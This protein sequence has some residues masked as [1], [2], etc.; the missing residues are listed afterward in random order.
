MR[1]IDVHTHNIIR[2]GSPFFIMNIMSDFDQIS[3]V[4]GFYSAG[5][6]PWYLMEKNVE[7]EFSLLEKRLNNSNVL[8]VG[9]CGLDKLCTI[10]WSLQELWFEKQVL[11]ANEVMKPLIV[12]C[13][14]AFDEILAM[15]K[16]SKVIVPVIFHGYEKSESVAFKILQ[17]NPN[18]YLS[19]GK[20]L[21]NKHIANVFRHIPDDRILLET[22]SSSFSIEEIY[23]KASQIKN[24]SLERLKEQIGSTALKIFGK[25]ILLYE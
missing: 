20:G 18:Y 25:S 11:L 16:A 14:R 23:F 21:M 3:H 9:E 22:D 13:V 6:H 10:E 1:F 8:A 5:L 17:Q 15:L 2:T 19:F 24:L 12:H 7:M 4:N